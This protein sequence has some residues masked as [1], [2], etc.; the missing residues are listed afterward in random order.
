MLQVKD[1]KKSYALPAAPFRRRAGGAKTKQALAG[2]SFALGPGL[3]GLLRRKCL[4]F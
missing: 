2:V 1:L 4:R 3:Y